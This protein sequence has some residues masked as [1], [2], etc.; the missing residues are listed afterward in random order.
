MEP[1]VKHFPVDRED[2]DRRLDM[3]ARD[4]GRVLEHHGYPRVNGEDRTELEGLLIEFI[5][6]SRGAPGE[7]EARLNGTAAPLVSDEGGIDSYE[8]VAV[9]HELRRKRGA[10][11]ALVLAM[12]ADDVL[13][14]GC[15]V[16]PQSKM[17]FL[18]GRLLALLD[19]LGHDQ[20]APVAL[21]LVVNES[22]RAS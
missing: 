11:G 21:D 7:L 10:D 17:D 15:A 4:V 8:C 16:E 2:G 20:I 1:Q 5:Y 14:I 13:H 9:A 19:D 12:D 3:L 18:S 6:G 22:G